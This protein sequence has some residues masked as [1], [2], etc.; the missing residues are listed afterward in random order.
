[1][2][3]NRNLLTVSEVAQI[4]GRDRKTVLRWI[5]SGQL[6]A[7]KL[8]GKTGAYVISSA[9]VTALPSADGLCRN[10]RLAAHSAGAA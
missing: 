5:G 4:V 3:K 1:M 8:A 2:P 7:I 10:C 9:S 6:E